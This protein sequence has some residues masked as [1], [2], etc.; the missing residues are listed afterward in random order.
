MPFPECSAEGFPFKGWGPGVQEVTKSR[1][2]CVR[3][4]A[5]AS[6]SVVHFWESKIVAR[7]RTVVT[8]GLV[9]GLRVSKVP[10][11]NSHRDRGFGLA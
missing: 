2:V 6:A 1:C 11:V 8:F 4:F 5:K 10:I 9:S 3:K 7:L